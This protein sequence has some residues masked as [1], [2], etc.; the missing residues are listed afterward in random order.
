VSEL[1]PD[2]A[3]NIKKLKE[4]H[5]MGLKGK[6]MDYLWKNSGD[7][8]EIHKMQVETADYIRVKEE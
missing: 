1:P 5:Y 2:L 6:E 4:Q 7:A 3:E 8:Q